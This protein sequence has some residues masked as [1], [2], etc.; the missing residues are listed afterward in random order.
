MLEKLHVNG[1]KRFE[2]TFQFS[3][4]FI[5][6]YNED[7]DEGYLLEVNVQYSEKLHELNISLACLPENNWKSWKFCS[8]LASWKQYLIH[9]KNLKQALNHRLVSK[10]VHRIIKFNQKAWLKP[11]IDMNTELTK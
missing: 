7:N 3:K 8:Q 9:I 10:K 2:N 1:F 4:H 11:Y 6:N 5:E